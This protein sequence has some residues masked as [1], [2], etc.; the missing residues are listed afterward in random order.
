M[1][2]QAGQ[3]VVAVA[4]VAQFA[5]VVVVDARQHAFQGLGVGIFQGRAGLVQG[6]ADVGRRLLKLGPA[7]FLRNEEI[8]LVGVFRIG[9]P[10][11]LEGLAFLLEAIRQPLQKQQA[12]DVV[13]VVA[14]IDAAAKDVGRRPQVALQLLA[15]QLFAGRNVDRLGRRCLAVAVSLG[16]GLW[17]GGLGAPL[18][19]S[20]QPR[21]QD[22]FLAATIVKA[23]G[24]TQL[25]EPFPAEIGKDFGQGRLLRRRHRFE[26]VVLLPAIGSLQPK[27]LAD[28]NQLFTREQR[29]DITLRRHRGA[30]Y[31]KVPPG[32]Q[33][34]A[35]SCPKSRCVASALR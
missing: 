5:L 33:R 35:S 19:G 25:L 23:Q 34:P 27:L 1:L 28:G 22:G 2:D 31:S 9:V 29:Q 32:R 13:L 10:V 17:P 3:D 7:G 4:V 21:D 6:F 8:V 20:N 11:A 18:A 26:E 14:G 12:Q 24:C 30:D 16:G 15:G